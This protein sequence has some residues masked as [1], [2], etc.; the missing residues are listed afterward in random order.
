MLDQK[1]INEAN[2][3]TFRRGIDKLQEGI[4]KLNVR[5][6][7][8]TEKGDA[9]PDHLMSTVSASLTVMAQA[10]LLDATLDTK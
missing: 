4:D 8:L 2:R 7:E 1:S 10:I 5:L 9:V 3:A 6:E